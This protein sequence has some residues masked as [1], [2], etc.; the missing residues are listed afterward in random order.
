LKEAKIL[1]D[2]KKTELINYRNEVKNNR[3]RKFLEK[4]QAPQS[5]VVR[6]VQ[7]KGELLPDE[8]EDELIEQYQINPL[9][10]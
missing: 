9:E 1:Y 4:N 6:E 10:Q 3:L 5:K 8:V 2:I 7:L